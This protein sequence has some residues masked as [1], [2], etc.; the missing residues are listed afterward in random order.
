M[1]G[2]SG[3][4]AHA[5]FVDDIDQADELPPLPLPISAKAGLMASA[6]APPPKGFR[7]PLGKPA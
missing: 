6:S 7:V 1:T 2:V 5:V 3:Y 4:R